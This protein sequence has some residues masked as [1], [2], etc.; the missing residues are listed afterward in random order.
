MGRWFEVAVVSTCPYYMQAQKDNPA[1]VKYELQKN[2]TEEIV[3]QMRG[4]V[5]RHGTCKQISVDFTLT[6]TSGQFY[7]HFAKFNA[8]VDSYVVNTDYEDYAMWVILS[9]EQPSGV[10]STIVK[11]YSRVMDVRESVLTKYR[12]LVR[13]QG[14]DDDDIIFKDNK[15]DGE[16][17]RERERERD[18]MLRSFVTIFFCLQASVNGSPTVQS[19]V[20]NLTLPNLTLPNL[21]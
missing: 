19:K 1:V 6:N 15:G 9:T 2:T 11:L 16:R 10:L 12:A 4:T 18:W 20:P 7:H 21:T 13:T 3:V 8:D 14:M 17:E 5:P